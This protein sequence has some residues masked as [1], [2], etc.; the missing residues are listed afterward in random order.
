MIIQAIGIAALLI[1]TSIYQTN[2]RKTMLLLGMTASIFWSVHFLLLGAITGAAMNFTAAFRSYIYIKV[3]P[4][5]KNVWVMWFFLGVLAT[6]TLLTW[7]GVLSLLPLV[8]SSFSVIGDWQKKPKMIRRLNLGTSPPWLA[9][10]IISGSYP[11]AVVEVL[12]T[13]SNLI[14]Q[15]RFD[16]RPLSRRKLSRAAK[17]T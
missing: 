5:R 4:S 13:L 6:A 12:K 15:Y 17:T 16:F 7:Q 1:A 9:Y 11:G 14:G 10:N 3:K 2:T 8:G